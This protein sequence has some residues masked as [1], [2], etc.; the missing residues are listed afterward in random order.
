MSL[1]NCWRKKHLSTEP[2]EGAAL[3]LESIDNIESSDGL[4]AGVLSV[5]HGIANNVLKEHLEDTAGL[6][7][8]EAG[9][10]LDTTTTSETADSGLGDALDVVTQHLAMTLRATLAEAFATF[11]T[12]R[13]G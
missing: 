8:D 2:V 12:S 3:A 6:F 9:D 10:T 7:V 11:A 13:H 4:A 1:L 5:G